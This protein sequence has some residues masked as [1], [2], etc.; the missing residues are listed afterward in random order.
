[1]KDN[2]PFP[3][4]KSPFGPLSAMCAGTLT[5]AT[6][7][8]GVSAPADATPE[9]PNLVFILTDD[10]S[11]TQTSFRMDPRVPHSFSPYLHTPNMQRLAEQGMRFTDGYASAPIC[12]PTRRSILCGMTTARQ[13]GTEF[14]SDFD[15]RQHLTIPKALKAVDPA[16]RC[17]H[18]GKWG[19]SMVADPEEAGYDES[20]GITG[21][22][23]GDFLTWEEKGKQARTKT[24]RPK[25]SPTPFEDPKR[26]FGV[27]ERATDF[28]RRQAEASRPFYVQVSHYAVH[29]QIQARAETLKKYREKGKGPRNT[30][31]E[32]AAMLEDLDASI[33]LLLDAID[34]LGIADNT[35][36]ILG[37]DNGGV[38]HRWDSPFY[39]RQLLGEVTAWTADG[40]PA[41][42]D[43][44]KPPD[45]LPDN[46]PL[47]GAKQWLYE[48][49]IRV[50]FLARGP[51]I[52]AG[53]LTREPVVLY[54]LLPTLVDL[55]GGNVSALPDE[56]DGGSLKPL[57]HGVGG[58]QRALPGLV[59]HRPLLRFRGGKLTGNGAMSAF[60]SGDL[61]LVVDQLT[62]EKF[63]YDLRNDPG[64]TKDLAAARPADVER[65]AG[66]LDG[67]LKAVDA[68]INVPQTAVGGRKEKMEMLPD[69][70]KRVHSL[71]KRALRGELERD[72]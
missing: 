48:G 44:S 58:V 16:Y 35:Y 19:E 22:H 71:A 33:G 26:C 2:Q 46:Y 54:D 25:I 14:P 43:G 52:E 5:A 21:N 66:E 6:C 41:I 69:Q 38:Q 34:D 4:I 31:P 64:E 13:R 27:T 7:A 9:R 49:G 42:P 36:V 72:R 30:P 23:T 20:D 1:M 65:L 47:R 10:Q 40:E 37:A 24:K 3:S 53:A 62:G 61:K 51:G 59:F 39:R 60:R 28:M 55:A 45:L 17:A 12:T 63:L 15:P 8:L 56:I 70:L 32:F 29:D 67:Y 50:P 57:L 18:F 68:E 11:W